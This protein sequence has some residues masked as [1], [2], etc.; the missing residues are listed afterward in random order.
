M[1]YKISCWLLIIFS[2]AIARVEAVGLELTVGGWQQS[3]NGELGY[4]PIS[5]SDTIDLEEDLDFDDENR[6]FGRI[7]LDLPIFFPNIYLVGAPAEFDG[8]GSKSIALNYGDVTFNADAQLD[9][10]ITVNQYDIGFYYGLPFVKTG[11]AGMLNVDM[12]LNIRIFDLASR[13]TG[14]SGTTTVTERHSI[15]LPVPMLYLGVQIMPTDHFTIEAEGRGIAIGDDKIFSLLG[16]LRYQWA[17]PIFI[18]CGYRYDKIDVD[19]D[20]VIAD[21]DFSGPLVEVGLSF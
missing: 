5:D 8:T 13:I 9:S 20:D 7:K 12:G 15:T 10:K 16:R 14:L 4:R 18:S 19:E 1:G 6:L 3:I 2:L 11:S 21:V 17:G